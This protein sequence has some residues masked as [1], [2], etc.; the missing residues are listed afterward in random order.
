MNK[1]RQNIAQ[2]L[3]LQSQAEDPEILS[4]FS[5]I[6]KDKFFTDQV[7]IFEDLGLNENFK[8]SEMLIQVNRLLKGDPKLENSAWDLPAKLLVLRGL[9]E[10]RISC[11]QVT[12]SLEIAAKDF[13]ALYLVFGH[14]DYRQISD[15]QDR[16]EYYQNKTKY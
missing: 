3:G 8:S 6:I 7:P 4:R 12:L 13:R 1:L 15:V 14:K 11:D 10:K 9:Y 16:S 2:A 5:E